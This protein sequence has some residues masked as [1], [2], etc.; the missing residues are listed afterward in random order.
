MKWLL[1]SLLAI[2]ALVGAALWLYEPEPEYQVATVP[3]PQLQPPLRLKVVYLHNPRF[4]RMTDEQLQATLVLATDL[5]RQHFGLEVE[6][7][8][9]GERT[10][11]SVFEQ[12]PQPVKAYRERFIV[13]PVN[14]SSSVRKALVADLESTLRSYATPLEELEAF[15]EPYLVESASKGYTGLADALITTL[16]RRQNYWRKVKALDGLPVIREGEHYHEWVWWDSLGYAELDFDL[17]L[18]NQLVAS[19]ESYGQDIHSSLRGGIT[20]G[21]TTNS[22]SGRYGSF[23]WVSTFPVLND[24]RPIMLLRDEQSFSEAQQIRYVAAVLTHEI[25]HLL[26]HLSHPWENKACVMTPTPI[27]DYAGWFAG[28]DA[29]ACP[30][31]SSPANT[32]G[33]AKISYPVF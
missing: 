9:R 28:L 4:I 10:L 23:A 30:V 20:L 29:E 11:A 2:S 32:P 12:I 22:K 31:G 27:L 8:W 13:N 1:G 5:V 3:L 21:T 24:H 25:G 14:I 33:A 17:A 15:A 16:L 6:L 18:T 7:D 26:L 19:V